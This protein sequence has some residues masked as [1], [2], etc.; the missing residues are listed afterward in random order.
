MRRWKG[1]GEE[2][3]ECNRRG[4]QAGE[5]TLPSLLTP[6]SSLLTPNS[7]LHTPHSTLLTPHSSLHTSHSTEGCK[8][9]GRGVG[10]GR[11]DGRGVERMGRGGKAKVTE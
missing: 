8:D 1:R 7:S 5:V 10:E 9:E 2:E 6:R 11:G 4:G 3:T